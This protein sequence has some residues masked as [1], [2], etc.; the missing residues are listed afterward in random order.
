MAGMTTV[1]ESVESGPVSPTAE[2]PVAAAGSEVLGGPLGRRAAAGLSR[3][4]PLHVLIWLA[5]GMFALGMAQK[6]PCYNDGWFHGATTQYTR[7]CYSDVPH[8]FTGRGFADGLTPYF[9]RLPHSLSGGFDYLEYPVLTGAF[10][11]LAAWLTPG[12]ELIDRQQAFWFANAA[13]LMIC[14][15]VTVGAVARTHRHRPWDALLVALA[16]ALALTATINWDLLAVALTA[17]AMALWSRRH[18]LAAGVCIGLATSAKIYPAL[19]LGP[20]LVLCLR[21]GRMRHFG[22]ALGGAVI[23][24]LAANLPLLLLAP[25]GW[26]EAYTYGMD[27]GADYG[28]FWLI[29]S[30][31]VGHDLADVNVYAI[32]VLILMCAGIAALA[33]YA[34]R[35]PRF[36]QLTFLVVAAFI[37]ANKVY[38]PQ[39]VLWLIPLAALARP[40]WRDF[41]IWQAAEVV[42]FF[43][44]WLYLANTMSADHRGLPE[45][46]YHVAIAIHLL[47]TLYL[48]TVV[49][50]D[51]LL[52]DRDPVRRD[53]VDDPS[54]GVL[55]R[56]PD[57]FVLGA[58]TYPYAAGDGDEESDRLV[59]WGPQQPWDPRE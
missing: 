3:W 34:P 54:G 12:G 24:W 4:S 56:A 18:P 38:S 37:L 28:S 55:D 1:R 40:R 42:Y 48:C 43:A 51:I 25:H 50:R 32:A 35:R 16:P 11:Q 33:L 5:I 10:M 20:L 27:R 46:A 15:L 7:A 29:L 31:R 2:D 36:A 23:A 30:Q 49:M 59:G 26:A 53:G 45:D 6:Y 17:V 58:R 14:A 39:Y 44:I 41:L 22:T 19:L 21:A 52:P 47:G 13:L 57:C 8:L 9:D